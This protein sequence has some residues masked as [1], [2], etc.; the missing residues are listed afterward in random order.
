VNATLSNNGGEPRN[1]VPNERFTWHTGFY[2]AIQLELGD[3]RSALEYDI[4]YQLT[5]EPLRIDTVVIKKPKD[6]VINKN[7]ALIFREYNIVEYKRP[8]DTLTF[9]D[10]HKVTGGYAGLYANKNRLS[11]RAMTATFV[12]SG[13]PNTL[14]SQ[15]KREYGLI[16]TQHSE[17]VYYITGLLLP[18]QILVTKRLPDAENVWLKNLSNELQTADMLAVLDADKQKPEEISASA[19]MHIVLQSNSTV[20]KE[21][22]NMQKTTLR[23][24]LEESGLTAEWEQKAREQNSLEIAKNL[25]SLGLKPEQIAQAVNMDVGRVKALY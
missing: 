11:L 22:M 19:Y 25:V 15:L 7:I 2:D 17:G 16:P 13:Y 10:F 18:I 12:V 3:F 4:E 9:E 24:V 23:Q 8:G 14:V 20:L 5:G 6:L 1:A 21:V